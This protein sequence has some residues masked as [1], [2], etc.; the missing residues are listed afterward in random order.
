VER[1][2]LPLRPKILYASSSIGS[3]ALVQSRSTWLL[4]YYAPPKSADMHTLLPV[5][6]V[7]AIL[8]VDGLTGALY[9]PLV[10]HL[11]DRTASR[12]G[13]RLPYIIGATPLWAL[14]ALLVFTPPQSAGTAVIAAYLFLTLELYAVFSTLS[15]GP[16]Q[17]LLP[18]IAH[19]SADRVSLVGLR[20]YAGGLGGAAGLV[21][22]G[23]LVDHLSF[24]A[25][26]LTMALLALVFRYVGMAGVWRRASRVQAPATIPFRESLRTTFANRKFQV[27]VPS[28]V[29]FQ[30]GVQMILGVLPYYVKAVLDVHKPGTWVA[31]LT[32]VEIVSM[33]ASVQLGARLARRTSKRHAYRI[34]MIGAALVFPLLALTGLVSAIPA[35]V[36]IGIVMA[37]AGVP[38]SGVYLFPDALT[39]DIIDQD[40]VET[41]MRREAMYYGAGSFVQQAA[42][43]LGPFLL[44]GL[45][46]L[47]DTRG[48]ELGLRLVGPF[49]GV[50]VL[51]GY[52]IFRSYDLPDEVD[53]PVI[54]G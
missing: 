16:F 6:V 45:L 4:Y 5:A 39:A 14:F 32:A 9:N 50:L 47:G 28:V 44:S 26:A 48:D 46:V 20:V 54:A 34:A 2:S 21:G 17:A 7:G 52:L 1:S 53:M 27:F 40:S 29:L 30:V 11:T 38:L 8:L 51:V 25:M 10:G 23:L 43:S 12:L 18:E 49:A 41:G 31:I 35:S 24:R 19:S 33:L 42:S 22:S 37:I 36:Q 13:R 3:E 15:G